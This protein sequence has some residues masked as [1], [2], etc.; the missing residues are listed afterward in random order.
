MIL[1][2]IF[3][4]FFVSLLLPCRESFHSLT[5]KMCVMVYCQ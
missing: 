1:K 2:V 4:G 5:R 3:F